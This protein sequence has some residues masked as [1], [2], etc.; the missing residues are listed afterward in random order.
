MKRA[1]TILDSD[2][3]FDTQKGQY[4]LATGHG[5]V[6]FYFGDQK[7]ILKDGHKHFFIIQD[8]K[9]NEISHDRFQALNKS[10]VW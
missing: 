2:L 10:K 4:I 7:L 5:S 8:G 6:E 3:K 1:T 9:I